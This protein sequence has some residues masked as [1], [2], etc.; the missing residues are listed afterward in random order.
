[1][2][3]SHSGERERLRA[4]T[5]SHDYHHSG[6]TDQ[7]GTGGSAE[8]QLALACSYVQCGGIGMSVPGSIHSPTHW[9]E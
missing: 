2:N 4:A 6:T 7:V 3:R 1:M 9:H 5:K 8:V